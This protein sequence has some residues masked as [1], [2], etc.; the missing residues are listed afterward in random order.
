MCS[1]SNTAHLSHGGNL[2]HKTVLDPV[3]M[4]PLQF[5]LMDTRNR[6][7]LTLSDDLIGQ[8]QRIKALSGVATATIVREMLETNIGTFKAMADALE[9]AEAKKGDPFKHLL[10]VLKTAGDDA[11]QLHL[12]I[13]NA[14]RRI[15]RSKKA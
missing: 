9:E 4:V 10:R 13:S 7:N 14:R 6:V 12:E 8:F 2:V 15:K 5:R 11:D 3:L 1:A